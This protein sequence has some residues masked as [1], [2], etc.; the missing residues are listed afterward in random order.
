M[1]KKPRY[2]PVGLRRAG[3]LLLAVTAFAAIYILRLAVDDPGEPILF[4]LVAP[5]G[6]LAA[7][8]GSVGGLAGAIVASALV[9]AWELSAGPHLTAFSYGIR[10]AVFFL[11]A[12]TVGTLANARRALEEQHMRWFEEVSDLNCVADMEGNFIRLNKAWETKLGY[13]EEDLL[14]TPYVAYVHPED[15]ERTV[16]LAAKLAEGQ[17]GVVNFENRYLAKDGTYR[18]LRW[19]STSDHDR[20]VIYASA[21]DVTEQKELEDKLR[22]LARSDSLTGLFNRRH[23]DEEAQRQLDFVRRYGHRAAMLVF[24]IDNFK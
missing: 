19:S 8:F 17:Q 13:S 10:W 14:S 15:R 4:L 9:V 24:D 11:A 1:S 16:A 2:A 3:V 6:L 23:F 7:E 5:I 18:W 12:I 22:D 21:R 20:G